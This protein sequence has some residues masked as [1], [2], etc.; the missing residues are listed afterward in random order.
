MK[1]NPT[2][3]I[4]SFIFFSIVFLASCSKDHNPPPTPTP[5]P[6]SLT[7]TQL[8]VRS[9]WQVDEVFRNISGANSHYKRGGEN[10][11]G[12]NYDTLQVTFNTDGSGTYRDET[13]TTHQASWS[14]ATPDFRNVT[15]NIGPPSATTYNWGLFE[16]TGDAMY[17]TTPVGSNILVAARY[18]PLPRISPDK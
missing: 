9:T 8:L 7:K 4:L 10:T 18:T 2:G 6:D 15:F 13:G 3:Y 14:F 1:K 5:C 17:N 16:V 11:T 12:T